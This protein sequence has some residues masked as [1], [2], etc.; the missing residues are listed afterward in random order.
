MQNAPKRFMITVELRDA[1][2]E[3]LIKRFS[4]MRGWRDLGRGG[5]RADASE[6]GLSTG[7]FRREGTQVMSAKHARIKWDT[8]QRVRDDKS[9]DELCSPVVEIMDLGSTNGT[10]LRRR[11]QSAITKLVPQSLYRIQDGDMLTFGK[12]LV[13]DRDKKAHRPL[14]LRV[15]IIGSEIGAGDC[16]TAS[17]PDGRSTTAHSP[18][19]TQAKLDPGQKQ[20]SVQEDSDTESDRHESEVGEDDNTMVITPKTPNEPSRQPPSKG[21]GL[22]EEQLVLHDE[23]NTTVDH[24]AFFSNPA[25]D[26]KLG[27][28]SDAID[29]TEEKSVSDR[30]SAT[31]DVPRSD[32]ADRG[33]QASGLQQSNEFDRAEPVKKTLDIVVSL[34]QT[35]NERADD[36]PKHS[37]V[38]LIEHCGSYNE[39]SG[40]N[41]LSHLYDSNEDASMCESHSDEEESDEDAS[42]SGFDG[43]SSN[44]D[45]HASDRSSV[46]NS[47][48]EEISSHQVPR[49][50]QR[51]K[52]VSNRTHERRRVIFS[53]DEEGDEVGKDEEVKGSPFSYSSRGATTSPSSSVLKPSSPPKIHTQ[54]GSSAADDAEESVDQAHR[55][56]SISS[57]ASM[58]SSDHE[59]DLASQHEEEGEDGYALSSGIPH[60]KT[61]RASLRALDCPLEAETQEKL[62]QPGIEELSEPS[63]SS[64]G[65]G[66]SEH[67]TPSLEPTTAEGDTKFAMDEFEEMSPMRTH[68]ATVTAPSSE[69]VAPYKAPRFVG[70]ASTGMQV[71]ERARSESLDLPAPLPALSP[72]FKSHGDFDP[73]LDEIDL[74][75]EGDEE[76]ALDSDPIE[77][78]MDPSSDIDGQHCGMGRPKYSDTP[79]KLFEGIVTLEKAATHKPFKVHERYAQ[80]LEVHSASLQF[81]KKCST[82]IEVIQQT[83][84]NKRTFSDM[85]AS[86]ETVLRDEEGQNLRPST[87]SDDN[88]CEAINNLE[89]A[90]LQSSVSTSNVYTPA[91]KRRRVSF[92]DVSVGFGVGVVAT[93]WGLTAMSESFMQSIVE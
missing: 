63:T 44:D 56:S 58:S 45:S 18:S 12:H 28:S 72:K 17:V 8:V 61:L 29:L 23:E 52:S 7:M 69:V 54:P 81:T 48:C 76:L 5:H 84:S 77:E 49:P 64:A 9:G 38:S 34:D 10:D 68:T 41:D 59:S 4:G 55:K 65:I 30:E 74:F 40:D 91:P 80:E 60:T 83:P 93:L 71:T 43:Y 27:V 50:I 11:G 62:A 14:T 82:D 3:Q 25:A 15:K 78:D 88:K 26:S 1:E 89:Q 73:D 33:S 36:R 46:Y 85:E 86:D 66:G 90:P 42:N 87:L 16:V 57:F 22:T 37:L 2:S 20:C 67:T 53:S 6:L 47:D 51:S 75:I 13:G 39:E 32:I 79:T 19:P 35:T 70:V 21:Y 92:R 31:S 24:K